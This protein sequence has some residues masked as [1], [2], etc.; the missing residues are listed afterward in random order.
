MI[1]V[2]ELNGDEF[3]NKFIEGLVKPACLWDSRNRKGTESGLDYMYIG[4]REMRKEIF[5]QYQYQISLGP[6][7]IFLQQWQSYFF[8]I[9]NYISSKDGIKKEI[10]DLDLVMQISP[11]PMLGAQFPG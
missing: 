6:N 1:I 10:L 3:E 7:Y 4:S 9:D 2:A 11:G 5:D 8:Y